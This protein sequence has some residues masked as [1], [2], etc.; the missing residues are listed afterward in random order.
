MKI[1]VRQICF[2]LLAYTAVTKILMYPTILS[3]DC[4]RDL[5]LPALIDFTVGGIVIWSLSYLC[6]KTDKTFFALLEGIIGNVGA[7]IVYGF[8]AAF[9]LLTALLPIFEQKMYIHN[10]FYDTVPSLGVFL[11]FFAFAVYAASKKFINIGRCADIC[12]PLFLVCMILMFALG[13]GEAK[14]DNLLPMFK[15]PA[16]VLFKCTAGTLYNFAEPC[17][18]LMMMGHFKYKK[19]DA[20]KITLSYA[21]GAAF[22]L[23]FLTLFMGIYGPIAPSRTFAIARTSLFFPAIETIGRIDLVLLFVL[24]VVMLFALVLNIQLGVYAIYKCTGYQNYKIISL[25]VNI[26]LL[27][28]TVFA[29]SQY[30][31]IYNFYYDWLWIAFAVFTVALPLS[32]W[33]F[34]RRNSR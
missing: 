10:I 6:S 33:A 3:G 20:A 34:K 7:R 29:D 15:A 17:W 32:A 1:S 30:S 18:L 26:A 21:G 9:F 24:E 13:F 22:V 2:I 23:L 31:G 25:A 27:T 12:L 4:N 14:M 11:P 28:I 19:G 8:I 5:L 16:G